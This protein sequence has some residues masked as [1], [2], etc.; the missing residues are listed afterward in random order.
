MIISDS[1]ILKNKF[2]Q[3]DCRKSLPKGYAITLLTS[4][5]LK[6]AGIKFEF[7][8]FGFT[9]EKKPITFKIVGREGKA[10][11][12]LFLAEKLAAKGADRISAIQAVM[13]SFAAAEQY[14][15]ELK[16]KQIFEVESEERKRLISA[17][18][19]KGFFPDLG[20]EE[21][22]KKFIKKHNL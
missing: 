11:L 1:F 22:I 7:G 2:G 21:K 4:Q 15:T 10:E 20:N 5:E 14:L 9:P 17:L 13:G 6:K 12:F 8:L 16:E 3:I 19:A 18:E